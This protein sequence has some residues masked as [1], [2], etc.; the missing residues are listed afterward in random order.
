MSEVKFGVNETAAAAPEGNTAV[1]TAPTPAGAVATR[2][3]MLGDEI[4]SFTS[5]IMPRVAITQNM[6]ELLKKFDAGTLVLNNRIPLFVPGKG[7]TR[8]ATPAVN[9]VFLGIQGRETFVEKTKTGNGIRVKT[10]AAV[11][12]AGGTTDYGEWE[13][14]ASSGMK[15]FRPS[16]D[17]VALIEQPEIA[18]KSEGDFPFE[19]EGK[20]YALGLW[21][22][23]G[24]PHTALARGVLY[25][26]RKMGVL[27]QGGYPSWVFSVTTF[28]K[29]FAGGQKHAWVPAAEPVTKTAPGTLAFIA[30]LLKA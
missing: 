12:A 18:A 22:L 7:D 30:E 29:P 23:V 13:L 28:E 17:F 16:V 3:V 25:T 10:E 15:L 1:L 6:G 11:A 9:I 2:N 21:G 26:A 4:P 5:I 14:K 20:K 27:L 8:K 19:L 24:A